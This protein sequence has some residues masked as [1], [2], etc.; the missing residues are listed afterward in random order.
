[1][2]MTVINDEMSGV[3]AQNSDDVES[4]DGWMQGWAGMSKK[5]QEGPRNA[6]RRLPGGQQVGSGWPVSD[7][8]VTSKSSISAR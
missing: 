2:K 3:H 8:W 7:Q 4:V 1:M 5:D 6:G